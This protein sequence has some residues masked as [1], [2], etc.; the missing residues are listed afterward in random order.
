PIAIVG[1]ACRYPGGVRS[2]EDLWRVVADGVD[3]VGE[4]PSDR[5][6]DLERLF[7]PDPGVPNTVYAREGGFLD[8][9]GDFD[10]GFFGIGPREA[11]AM[12]PQ[13][14]LMLE[15]SWEALEDAGIDPMSLRGS[16]VGV[17]AGVIH[18]HYGPRVGSP[19]VSAETEGHAYLGVS[20]SVLSGRIA[21]TLGFQGPAV[22]VDTACSSS[23][24]ALHL[25]CQALR[26]GEAGLALAG[27]VT[28]MSDPSLL[29]AFARQRALSPDGRCKAF[30]AAADGTGF[31]EGLGMLVLERLS[32]AR[33]NGHRV[34][35]VIRGSAVNQ[36]GAS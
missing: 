21:Y 3:A 18:Q 19:A 12:D 23:L 34:L 15:A 8:G 36:D 25:A 29:I 31:S 32:D 1:M 22:S 7:D 20:N 33:R 10:A 2:A 26:Q 5:G 14:R 11:A 16:E 28:V 35:A 9:I 17:F 27:G 13:Q 24:V 4:Y 30:A 6:W